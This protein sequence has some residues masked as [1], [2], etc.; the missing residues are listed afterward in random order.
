MKKLLKAASFLILIS[1][2]SI[3]VE[4]CLC[5]PEDRRING[6][7]EISIFQV[8]DSTYTRTDT[9]VGLFNLYTNT[10]SEVVFNRIN[11]ISLINSAYALSCDPDNYLNTL[12]ESTFKL[13]CDKDFV[14]N[15]E[16]IFANM[17]YAQIEEL[18]VW[19]HPPYDSEAQIQVT[20]TEE[21]VNKAQFQNTDYTF[22]FD[23]ETDDGVQLSA[24]KTLIMNL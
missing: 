20:F 12:D 21:F 18:D 11:N 2:Y 8:V 9:V 17:D 16:T 10:E 6:L 13:T 15:N 1:V 23:I 19:I 4:G 3:I 5:P 14:Y 24:E 7:M 22:R